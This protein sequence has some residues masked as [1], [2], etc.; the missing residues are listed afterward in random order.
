VD[1]TYESSHSVAIQSHHDQ[2][3]R[4]VIDEMPVGLYRADLVVGNDETQLVRRTLDFVKLARRHSPPT[5]T[6]LGFGVVLKD[7]DLQFLAGQAELMRHLRGE[8]VKIPAWR[9]QQAAVAGELL[10]TKPTDRY[11]EAIV[12]SQADPIGVLQDDLTTDVAGNLSAVQLMLDMFSED[13]LLWKPLVA[14]VWG[15]YAGLIHVWQLGA[16]D[17]NAVFLD[18][19]L[20]DV[21]VTLREEMRTLMSN[22][23]LATGVPVFWEPTRPLGVDYRAFEIPAT[24]PLESFADYAEP[25]ITS[26][27]R[28]TWITV[29]PLDSA[30]YPREQRLADLARRLAEARFLGVGGVFLDA[31]WKNE[32]GLLATQVNP[33]EDYIV[34]RT[35]ADM[36]GDAVPVARM[37]IRGWAQ[38]LVFDRNGRAIVF[39]WDDYAP[40]EG[41]EHRL[42][43]GEHARQVDLW[44]NIRELPT[45]GGQQVVRIGPTPTFIMDTPT[46]LMEF[47]RQF[48]FTPPL[49][50]ASFRF[51]ERE[52][53]FTNTYHDPISGVVKLVGPPG[54]DIRPPKIAFA[55]QPGEQFKTGVRLRFPV[56]AE[57]EVKAVL[58]DFMIDADRRMRLITPAWFELGLEDI[59]VHTYPLRTD[60]RI[61]VRTTLTNRTDGPVN[62]DADLV[63]PGRQRIERLFANI[64]P[65]QTVTKDFVIRDLE[66]LTGPAVRLALRERNGS[67]LFNRVIELP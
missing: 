56:N 45:V 13:S 9:A 1:E 10:D 67:R 4:I 39:A 31:P 61:I 34:L 27:P 6:G 59:D 55:L 25:L 40:P 65:G 18:Y 64:V 53:A 26:P 21:L 14:T 66:T 49:L 20:P 52:I 36:L 44:G 41:R 28:H 37:T 7:T 38:C 8:Y 46:W 63:V 50:E 16:D 58:G 22:P 5:A 35:L 11:L 54:W 33:Q 42:L 51:E 57:S 12:D 17:D 3:Q 2:A 62:F 15:R 32:A 24:V 30:R 19:R 23:L 47:R 29:E 43:L 48:V 60:D